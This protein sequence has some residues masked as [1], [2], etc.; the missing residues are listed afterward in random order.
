MLKKFLIF[1]DVE[2]KW[3]NKYFLSV[4]FYYL[5]S[6][7]CNHFFKRHI[8]VLKYCQT[9]FELWKLK[10][11]SQLQVKFHQNFSNLCR[12]YRKFWTFMWTKVKKNLLFLER[13]FFSSSEKLTFEKEILIFLNTF[14]NFNLFYL[15]VLIFL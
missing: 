9:V 8:V 4:I 13:F 6:Y 5:R 1:S 7:I 15:I 10:I 12:M 2:I 14:L 11:H 3:R